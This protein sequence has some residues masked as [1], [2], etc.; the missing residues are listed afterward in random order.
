[1]ITRRITYLLVFLLLLSSGISF[2]AFLGRKEKVDFRTVAADIVRKTASSNQ[3]LQRMARKQDRILFSPPTGK[4]YSDKD[5]LFDGIYL[6]YF[7]NMKIRSI[8]L[9]SDGLANGTA[10]TFHRNGTIRENIPFQKGLRNGTYRRMDA[11]GHLLVTGTYVMGKM[12]GK[13]CLYFPDGSIRYV[14]TYKD[15]L[16]IEEWFGAFPEEGFDFSEDLLEVE[17]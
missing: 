8:V 16:L 9:F 12:E 11:F 3:P 6:E 13:W 7:K 4:F 1:M 17:D 2:Y 10:A 5:L 15:G 14:G